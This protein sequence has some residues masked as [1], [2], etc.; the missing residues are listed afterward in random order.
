MSNS[1]LDEGQLSKLDT[2]Q[3]AEFG[4]RV[5]A[6]LI[7]VLV[8]VPFIILGFYNASIW[9]SIPIFLLGTLLSNAYKPFMEWQYGATFG[10][11]AAKIKVVNEEIE[12]I[13]LE[14][15]IVRYFPWLISMAIGIVLNIQV[16]NA[17]EFQRI[18][19]LQKINEFTQTFPLQN[20]NSVFG[21]IF[22]V[23]VL[24]FV[25]DQRKQGLHD[26]AAK[27]YC[28]KVG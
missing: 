20:V 23:I 24:Y 16:Y 9:K 25:L 7:D 28:I 4:P 1:T 18:K 26:K 10:K 15:A 22:L 19:N 5:V 11:M 2:V 12:S 21:L 6:T 27:T 17:P 13:S 3:F 14:Q 8:L